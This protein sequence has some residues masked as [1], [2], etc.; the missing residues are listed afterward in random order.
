LP[1]STI[2]DV[3][4]AAGVSPATV[5]RVFNAPDTV[6]PELRGRV[7]AAAAAL[8]YCP[9]V[10]A[11]SLRTQR[12]RALGVVLPTLSNPVFAECL[13]GI[14]QAATAAGYSIVPFTTDY[15]LAH[16]RHAA[17]LLLARG[18]DALI[19][20]V[21]N[22]ARSSVLT[23][24]RLAKS[25]YVLIYNRHDRHP[26]VSVDGRAAVKALVARLHALGHRH[27]LMVSGALAASD[28]AQQRH[29][30]YLNGVAAVGLKPQ[31]LEVPFMDG[32]TERM[33][34][35]LA[36]RRVLPQ[37]PTAV[38]CSNDLLAIRCVRAAHQVGLRVPED[39]SVAGFDGIGLGEDMTPALS[40]IVQ[41]SAEIGRRSVELL[42]QALAGAVP[43]G[44]SH[45]LTLDLH[46]RA[47]ESIAAARVPSPASTHSLPR[48]TST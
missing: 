33:A 17:D 45:S 12:T 9:N 11:R 30:G 2:R 3:S 29:R 14:A 43:L 4:N 35:Y 28:R 36:A 21:A 10:S 20:C 38:V 44:P 34:R 1:S 15:K 23:R 26:C 32:A 27:I 41:P 48:R 7:Q 22:A 24:L 8:G 47:G 5:S 6:R 18:V 46:F 19:L 31:L 37:A 16:E 40:T 39:L 25:P 13:Q 42:V